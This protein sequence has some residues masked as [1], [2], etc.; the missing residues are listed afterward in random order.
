MSPPSNQRSYNEQEQNKV[1]KA[2][3]TIVY[4]R[5]VKTLSRL[6]IYI[7]L[8]L[9]IIIAILISTHFGSRITV[10]LADIFIPNLHITYVTGTINSQI[11]VKDTH[12][13]VDGI[14]VDIKEL[15]L[16]WLPMCLLKKQVCM[17][18]LVASRVLVNIDTEKLTKDNSS[19]D[20]TEEELTL[21]FGIHLQQAELANVKI[22]VDDM[23]FNVSALKT[24]AQW[25]QT[26]IRVN[27]LNTTGLLVSI[28]DLSEE[29]DPIN[30]HTHPDPECTMA[31]LPKVFMPIPIFVSNAKIHDSLLKLGKREDTFKHINLQASYHRFLLH[32]EDLELEHSDGKVKLKGEISLK[33]DYPMDLSVTLDARHINELPEMSAQKV[34]LKAKGGFKKL[35]I[36]AIGSGQIDFS[37]DGDI[38]LAFPHLPYHLKFNSKQLVWPLDTQL[39]SGRSIVLATDGDLNHQSVTLS[40]LINTPYQPVLDIDTQF[41]HSG[42]QIKIDHL[43]AKGEIGE[44]VASGE[45]NYNNAFSWDTDI[46]L[47][48]LKI[49]QLVLDLENPLPT[50]L[51][52]GQIKTK[53]TLDHQKWQVGLSQSNLTGELK[54]YPFHLLGDVTINDE[55]NLSADNLTF[56]A[57]QTM[58][59]MSGAVKETWDVN[60]ILDAPDLNLWHPDAHGTIKADIKIS[61]PKEHPKIDMT[62][63]A[64][65]LQFKQFELGKTHIKGHYSPQNAH[66]FSL[67]LNANDLKWQNIEIDSIIFDTNGD[68]KNQ[69]LALQTL[70]DLQLNTQVYSTFDADIETLN[71]Q[72]STFSLDSII[73]PWD[74]QSPVEITWNNPQKFGAISPFCWQHKEGDLCLDNTA[75]LGNKGETNVSFIGDLGSLLAP[76]LPENLTWD[77]P[78]KL[79]SQLSWQPESKPIGF[80][81]LHFDP[82][83]ISLNHNHSDL[84]MGYKLLNLQAVLDAEKLSTQIKFNSYD[85][86]NLEGRLDINVTPDRAISGYTKL[87]QMNLQSLSELMPQLEHLAGTVSSELTIAGTL[88]KPDISG[89]LS[90]TKGEL[91]I[92]ANPTVL[93]NINLSLSL[94]GQKAMVNGH[95]LMGEGAAT[96][97]GLLNWGNDQFTGDIAFNGDN[98]AIIKPPLVM[99]N[100]SPDLN[101]HFKKNKVDVQGVL[102]IL[103]GN[104][105]VAQLSKGGIAESQDV[106]FEDS[107]S[108]DSV[109]KNPLAIT[110]NVKINVFNKLKIDGMGLTGKLAG[111]LDLKQAAFRPPLLYGDI[112][113]INGHYTFLGQTLEIKTGEV[114]FIGPMAIPNLNIEAIRAIKEEEVI[115]GVRITGTPLKP[116]V[117]LFSSPTK[118]QA[119]ILSYILKGSGIK[120]S[121]GD[122]NNSLIMVAAL[123]LG[124]QLGGST[125]NN[126]S[127]SATNIIEKIGFS[128]VQFNTNDNGHVAISGFIGEDLMVKYGVGVFNPGYDV[129]VRYYLLSQLYLETVSGS[130]EQSL[131]IYYNFDID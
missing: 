36:H 17:D 49:E 108:S 81:D 120:D 94:L 34:T 48:N 63:H 6:L 32:V 88:N 98:L 84:D 80:V 35:V 109:A 91:L 115:A 30:K 57:L 112:R 19:T 39:Y 21:P 100:I 96:L 31:H 73:G 66:Q 126:I 11:E 65:Y 9:L 87:H 2:S 64:L 25:Q 33:D 24:R 78:A 12:W 114:Q 7:P 60:G 70:G 27:Y 44:L 42:T 58:L 8:S 67:S 86:A 93:E 117:T 110:T 46:S 129:T 102:N 40:G 23:Q 26:G 124:N 37:L 15:K 89:E 51:I 99:M 61:G 118:E 14:S 75:K 1:S 56:S 71:A 10:L 82:G 13:E 55:F 104:I 130:I 53:G 45:V 97:D 122:Q 83:H 105:K 76:F 16:K 107:I 101:I 74:L 59:T 50:S 29:T 38:G 18:E 28:P 90:L 72:I 3:F 68:E 127:H 131:D 47:K 5:S 22:S 103:S 95:W 69:Q 79:R 41:E 52:T 128:N 106:I 77:A 62:A 119:E 85:I 125:V 123:S 113:V 4:W 43:N 111:T 20:D 121:D 54:G 116:V 92:A